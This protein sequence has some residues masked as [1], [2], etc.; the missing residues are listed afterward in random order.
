MP[1]R[2]EDNIRVQ[3]YLNIVEI[4]TRVV[5]GATCKIGKSGELTRGKKRVRPLLT[6]AFD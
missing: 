6:T 5:H 2:V 1:K 4:Y 3:Q